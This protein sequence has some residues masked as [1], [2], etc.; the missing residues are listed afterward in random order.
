MGELHGMRT[1]SWVS[2]WEGNPRCAPGPVQNQRLRGDVTTRIKKSL[3]EVPVFLAKRKARRCSA[4][5]STSSSLCE[6]AL[7]PSWGY[8]LRAGL[9]LGLSPWLEQRQRRRESSKGQPGDDNSRYRPLLSQS[10]GPG[11]NLRRAGGEGQD[12]ATQRTRKMRLAA[13]ASFCSKAFRKLWPRFSPMTWPGSAQ[14]EDWRTKM[15]WSH[16]YASPLRSSWGLAGPQGRFKS[17]QA[18]VAAGDC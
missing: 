9:S 4:S 10:R 6:S 8:Q 15:A 2:N 12:T 5:D 18:I 7:L 14:D 13:R 16:L 11:W 1:K 3:S 17:P